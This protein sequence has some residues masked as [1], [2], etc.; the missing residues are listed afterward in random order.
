MKV[1]SNLYEEEK[2]KNKENFDP[3]LIIRFIKKL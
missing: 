3:S 2:Y 1:A